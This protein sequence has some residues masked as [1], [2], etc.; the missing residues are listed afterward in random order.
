MS[1]SGQGLHK[2]SRETL[3]S[4]NDD[5][6]RYIIHPSDTSGLF[7]TWRRIIALALIGLYAALPWIQIGGYPAVHL[8]TDAMRFHFFGLTF[9][10]HDIWLGFFLITGLGFGLFYATAL[11]GRIWCGW[12]CPQ[13]VFLEHVYRRV[14]RWIEGDA[15]KRRQLDRAP[16]RATRM[17][18][19][20]IK[21]A[22]FIVVSIA[23]AHLFM[24]YF[25]SVPKLWDMMR[26]SPGENWSVF[27]FVFVYSGLLYF[28]FAFFR[29][30]LCIVICPYGRLQ[31]ALIDD[32]SV[33]IGYD[34]KRGEPRGKATQ[35]G[36]GDCIDCN[37]C[38][39][40]CPT[41]ID[42]RQGLQMECV[43]C[44]NC[45]DACDEIME[46]VNR[47]KGLIRY[48]SLQSLEGKKTKWIRPR[49][50]AYTVLMLIGALVLSLSIGS[51]SSA[52][53]TVWR[54]GGPPYY[55]D[56]SYIRNQYMFRLTNRK[57]QPS[58]FQLET[59]GAE[60]D[61]VVNGVGE[62]ILIDGNGDVVKAVVV[63]VPKK[64]YKGRTKLNLNVLD[65]EGK[66]LASR[67]IEIVGPDLTHFR[68][69]E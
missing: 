67:P 61:M 57:N 24:A 42:I 47:P 51:L 19:R 54:L 8:D 12:A 39:Q 64:S 35:S 16:W 37:R 20:G 44:A 31:S 23:I 10:S 41:G 17:A 58:Y 4:V 49:T 27:L 45:I 28:N 63:L 14:E 55:I 5:G 52:S 9:L 50:I 68:S 46:K 40:V 48:G 56:D 30:Q 7:T 6:S 13:T 34:E 25:V 29:E 1:A 3:T 38:V 2:P 22:I 65:S 11:F 15:P 43:G 33:V 18:K 32:H 59:E 62:R 21:H 26:H 53:L 36:I 69:H 60:P 66:I